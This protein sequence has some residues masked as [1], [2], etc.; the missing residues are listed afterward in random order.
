MIKHDVL[1]AVDWFSDKVEIYKGCNAS[2]VTLIPKF[3]DPIGLTDYRPISLIGSYYKIIAKLLAERI[4]LFFI[5]SGICD[6]LI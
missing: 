3:I 4:L 6:L 5:F 2:F 1:K